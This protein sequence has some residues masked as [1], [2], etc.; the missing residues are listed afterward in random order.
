MSKE[1]II[2]FGATSNGKKSR[3]FYE[4]VLGLTCVEA[5]DYA[6]VYNCNGT[7]LRIQNVSDVSPQPHTM[8]GWSVKD[9]TGELVALKKRGVR[10]EIF[11]CLNT[12]ANPVWNSPSGAKVAWFKDPDGNT[13]SLTQL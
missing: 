1:Q 10:F 6:T 5:N 3:A 9:I 12:V 2:A 4:S 7:M 13:L 8:L 11:G